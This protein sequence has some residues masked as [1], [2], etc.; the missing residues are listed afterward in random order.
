MVF[1]GLDNAGKTTLLNILKEDKYSQPVPTTQPYSEELLMGKMKFRTFDLGG[2][3]IARKLWKDYYLLANAV[4]FLVDAAA[5]ER[6]GIAKEELEILMNCAE[7][8]NIP[9]VIL[10]NKIDKKGAVCEEELREALALPYHLTYGKELKKKKEPER[11]VEVFMC[12][13]AKRMGYAEAFQWVSTFL[14]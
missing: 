4:V 6:F 9:F 11:P 5:K 13:V 8:K 3:L 7:L 14:K 12:S 10:G 2:H 1:L